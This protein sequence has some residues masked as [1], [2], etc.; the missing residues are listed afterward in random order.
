MVQF[1][2]AAT[3]PE[4]MMVKFAYT[5]VAFPAVTTPVGLIELASLTEALIRH[6]DFID[7]GKTRD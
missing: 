1:A 7:Y 5:S 6:L 2:D 3:Y 4:A